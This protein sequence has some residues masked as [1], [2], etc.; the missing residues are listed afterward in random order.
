MSKPL[1]TDRKPKSRQLGDP[2]PPVS[3]PMATI[4]D[5]DELLLARI[6]Y[7]QVRARASRMVPAGTAA[8]LNSPVS[9]SFEENSPNGPLCHMLLVYWEFLVQFQQH[10]VSLL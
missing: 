8:N 4:Q 7:K 6:G 1:N 9:R 3:P 10:W 5:D 2:P